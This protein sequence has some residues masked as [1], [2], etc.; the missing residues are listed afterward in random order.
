[1]KCGQHEPIPQSFQQKWNKWLE[2]LEKVEN[3]QINRCFKP[4]D[5]GQITSAQMH[6]FSDAS[7][8]AYG[9]VTYIKFQ[10]DNNIVHI[11]FLIGKARVA[12]LKQ[13]TIP[14]LEL[15]AAVLTIKVDKMLRSE[16]QLPLEELQFW[17]DSTSV[18]K[19]IKN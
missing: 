17:T 3:F 14:R 7:E 2:D 12:P 10:N 11:T 19:Y 5:F 4:Q 9:T 13:V 1:M 18:L 15:T 6:H 16:L 8:T